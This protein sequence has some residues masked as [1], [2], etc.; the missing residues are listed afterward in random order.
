[1]RRDCPHLHPRL[2]SPSLICGTVNAGDLRRL[3]VLR[4][5]RPSQSLLQAEVAMRPMVKWQ[6]ASARS[7]R[8]AA[9]G[10]VVLA[11]RKHDTRT[12]RWQGRRASAVRP[13]MRQASNRHRQ[14]A[15]WFLRHYCVSV[16]T[17]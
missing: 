12:R 10:Q 11:L 5:V 16:A 9:H 1:M 17:A 13:R 15:G 8:P 7:L 6:F 14:L 3:R 4:Y 2:Q